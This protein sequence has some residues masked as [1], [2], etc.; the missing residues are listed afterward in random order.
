MSNE[1][2]TGKKIEI[3]EVQ[4]HIT[5]PEDRQKS[6]EKLM[7]EINYQLYNNEFLQACNVRK[8]SAAIELQK[9]I[10]EKIA[11]QQETV[12][13]VSGPSS[14]KKARNDTKHQ[15]SIIQNELTS[16]EINVLIPLKQI[17]ENLIGRMIQVLEDKKALQDWK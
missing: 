7:G 4:R 14:N 6:K 16:H 15:L 1:N 10:K 3:E 9:Q 11:G 2:N 12:N 8:L 5:S 13:G 17:R